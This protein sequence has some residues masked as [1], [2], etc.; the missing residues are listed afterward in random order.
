MP[1][2][3]KAQVRACFANKKKGNRNWDCNKWLQ[4]TRFPEAL[5]DRVSSK[6]PR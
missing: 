2:K 1:F 5:P 4:E 3:S 6:T